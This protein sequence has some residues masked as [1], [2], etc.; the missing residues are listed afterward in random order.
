MDEAL[1]HI[2]MDGARGAS[3]TLERAAEEFEAYVLKLLL[4]EMH[5]TLDSEGLFSGVTRTYQAVLEDALARRAAEAGTFGLARQL[6][7]SWGKTA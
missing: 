7:K 3:P 1:D 5:K 6:L 4:S 2:P